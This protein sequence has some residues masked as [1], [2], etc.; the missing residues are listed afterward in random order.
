MG[1]AEASPEN[2]ARYVREVLP[3]LDENNIEYLY[4]AMADEKWKSQ[5][6]GGPGAHWG[7][8]KSDGTVKESFKAS[9]PK[10]AAA[11]MKRRSRKMS[12]ND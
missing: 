6:E 8:L 11:G 2:A 9:M 10:K 3:L 4:F 1:G 12:F 5:D 7:L